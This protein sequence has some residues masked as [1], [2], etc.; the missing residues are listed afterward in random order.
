MTY[1]IMCYYGTF[2]KDEVKGGCLSKYAVTT[3][4]SDYIDS[5]V[6]CE[7]ADKWEAIKYFAEEYHDSKVFLNAYDFQD[8]IECVGVCFYRLLEYGD[9][10]YPYIIFESD[11]P[12]VNVNG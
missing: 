11:F 6:V 8:G 1:K 5:Y 7:F 9:V 10:E 2:A 4:L 3:Y 12:T